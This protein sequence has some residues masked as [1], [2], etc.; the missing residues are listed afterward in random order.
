MQL[1]NLWLKF[2][3][4]SKVKGETVFNYLQCQD[5][6]GQETCMEC[7]I[8]Q[9]TDMEGSKACRPCDVGHFADKTGAEYISCYH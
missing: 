5:E 3:V 4:S 7:P 2:S 9:F 8:G 6:Q 1:T